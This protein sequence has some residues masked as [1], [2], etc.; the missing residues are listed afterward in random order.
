M[1]NG[2]GED[3]GFCKHWKRFHPGERD[4]QNLEITFLDSIEDPGEK[5]KHYPNLKRLEAMWMTNLGTITAINPR[6]GLNYNDE[7]RSQGWA[8]WGSGW[9]T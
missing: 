5:E 3:C 6:S 7:A 1:V 2:V 8:V 4:L 9:K